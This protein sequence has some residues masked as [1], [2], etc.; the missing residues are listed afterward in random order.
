M[1]AAHGTLAA[2]WRVHWG[3]FLVLWG[4]KREVMPVLSRGRVGRLHIGGQ[5]A[6]PRPARSWSG[7]LAASNCRQCAACQGIAAP[8]PDPC[9]TLSLGLW[10]RPYLAPS[11]T[12]RGQPAHAGVGAIYTAGR[13]LGPDVLLKTII[14]AQTPCG[15]GLCWADSLWLQATSAAG[16]W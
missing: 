9:S 7:I 4:S 3:A 11:R 5:R 15:T 16:T 6:Q 10:H 8:S 12:C 13:I 1:Q 14:P 2:L